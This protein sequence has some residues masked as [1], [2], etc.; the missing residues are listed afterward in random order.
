MVHE[1]PTDTQ[2]LLSQTAKQL[3]ALPPVARTAQLTDICKVCLAET[4]LFDVV[5]FNRSCHPDNYPAGLAGTPVFYYRCGE[6]GFLYTR[7]MDEF[8]DAEWRQFVYND[9]YY[10]TLDPEYELRRPSLNAE[11]VASVCAKMDR[12]VLRGI[13]YG[14]GGG[15]L[16]KLLCERGYTYHTHDPYD[17]SDAP[18]EAVG[19]CTVLSA[20]EVL[21]HTCNPAETLEDMLKWAAPAFLAIVSTQCSEGLVD[22]A[23][24]LSWTYSAPRNGHVSIYTRRSLSLL[25]ARFGLEH[26]AISRGTHIFGRDLALGPFKNAVTMVKVRQRLRQ[27]VG[28]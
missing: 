18:A 28:R 3:S 5:D 19:Q 4:T 24:R 7:A 2:R 17:A 23:K 15:A 26:V 13:D 10:E 12:R 8:T 6:C 9:Y 27:W 22:D 21:E 14:G 11:L 25:V 16:A 1:T 20:F